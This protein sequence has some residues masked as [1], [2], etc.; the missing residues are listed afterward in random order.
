M[1]S[2]I[3]H[4]TCEMKGGF[5]VVLAQAPFLSK[6]PTDEET[7]IGVP[8][9]FLGEG[10]YFWEDHLKQAK[11]WGN[12]FYRDGYYIL[13]A[14]INTTDDNFLDLVGDRKSEGEFLLMIAKLVSHKDLKADT[15]L[16]A[17]L[18]YLRKA[19]IL[20]PGMFPYLIVRAQ[21]Y[22][23]L[24]YGTKL[25]FN[26]LHHYTYLNRINLFCLF[27]K[28]EVILSGKKIIFSSKI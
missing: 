12:T 1:K 26:D 7:E 28:D 25:L 19:N 23:H 14:D 11:W 4:H 6:W 10:Y 24:D 16:G 20:S 21:D 18:E 22:T 13:Q 2:Y 3:G 9:P 5:N 17:I 27:E 8:A 15:P